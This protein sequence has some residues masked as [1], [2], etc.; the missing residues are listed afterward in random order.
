[1]RNRTIVL[2]FILA[3]SSSFAQDGIHNKVIEITPAKEFFEK[4]QGDLRELERGEFETKEEFEQRS[5]ISVDTSTIWYLSTSEG[6]L[7]SIK[8][9]EYD[10]DSET[11]CFKGTERAKEFDSFISNR[12]KG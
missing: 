5:R 6:I 12:A 9:Y 4:C 11:L 1:M 10:I 2:A 7:A 8:P 3:S